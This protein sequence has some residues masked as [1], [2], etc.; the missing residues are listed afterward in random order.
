MNK[1][2]ELKHVINAIG[3]TRN[4]W[5]SKI[6]EVMSEARDGRR[7]EKELFS[8]AL[9]HQDVSSEFQNLIS[10]YG[11]IGSEHEAYAASIE[12]HVGVDAEVIPLKKRKAA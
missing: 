12:P 7:T 6:E 11:V 10:L 8:N 2:E 4:R 9:M 3:A 5:L 1:L